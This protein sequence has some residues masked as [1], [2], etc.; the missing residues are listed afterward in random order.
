MQLIFLWLQRLLEASFF[1]LF[2]CFTLL[3]AIPETTDPSQQVV[4]FT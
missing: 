1:D 4:W 2:G 3:L